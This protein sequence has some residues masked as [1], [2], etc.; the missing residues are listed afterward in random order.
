[1]R[2]S[3]AGLLTLLMVAPVSAGEMPWAKDYESARMQAAI[4]GR[5]IMI[6]FYADW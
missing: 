1:M 3:T 5:L 6:D 4:S 2:M